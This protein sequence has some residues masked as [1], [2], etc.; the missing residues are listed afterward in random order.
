M[1]DCLGFSL[2]FR[3]IYALIRRSRLPYDASTHFAQITYIPR[4]D[5]D[6][7]FSSPSS[8][9][10]AGLMNN[11]VSRQVGYARASTVHDSTQLITWKEIMCWP[12][13]FQ[14]ELM[15]LHYGVWCS[16]SVS[17]HSDCVRWVKT[18]FT[19]AAFIW[20]F[21]RD[22]TYKTRQLHFF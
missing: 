12:E 1:G 22:E 13:D 8:K 6:C 4:E 18:L 19:N 21:N 10:W 17:S 2:L 20:R 16:E 3:W 14:C 7:V 9:Q 5:I 15:S 11:G